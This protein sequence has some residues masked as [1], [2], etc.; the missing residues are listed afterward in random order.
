MKESIIE[1][2]KRLES[3]KGGWDGYKSKPIQKS[4][5]K[6]LKNI[7]FTVSIIDKFKAVGFQEKDIILIPLSDGRVQFEA[8]KDGVYLEVEISR[9]A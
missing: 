9:G 1:I 8:E 7:S 4:I 2:V 6:K 5:I 3:L